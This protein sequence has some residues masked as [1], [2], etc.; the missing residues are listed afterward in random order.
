MIEPNFDGGE[1]GPDGVLLLLRKIDQRIG[2]SRA[3][4]TVLSDPREA[5]RIKRPFHDFLA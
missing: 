3:A 5:A 2:L 1:T 4:A